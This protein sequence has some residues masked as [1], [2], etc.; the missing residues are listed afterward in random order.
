MKTFSPHGKTAISHPTRS[1]IP[2][3][4]K[5]PYKSSLRYATGIA[6]GE[7]VRDPI[8]SLRRRLSDDD[9]S[10][11]PPKIFEGVYKRG[12][13]RASVHPSPSLL[14]PR[15]SIERDRRGERKSWI[16]T[17]RRSGEE[18]TTFDTKPKNSLE[19]EIWRRERGKP[20]KRNPLLSSPRH[21]RAPFLFLFPPNSCQVGIRSSR[22]ATSPRVVDRP[23]SIRSLPR[24]K[25]TISSSLSL[26]SRLLLSPL[27]GR[28]I[29][30]SGHVVCT[31]VRTRFVYS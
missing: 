21:V 27:R 24:E 19:D 29:Y 11:P 5:P 17:S 15:R 7:P 9:R 10:R 22:Y 23:P 16:E 31:C 18:A 8:K 6:I 14:L 13:G 1:M 4:V 20:Q 3:P 26:A 2:S 12:W 28:I 25:P 30:C